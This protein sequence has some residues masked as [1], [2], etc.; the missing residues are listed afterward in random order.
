MTSSS[1]MECV[2]VDIMVFMWFQ[3]ILFTHLIVRLMIA[4][5]ILIPGSEIGLKITA[6]WCMAKTNY[7]HINQNAV[8][9][10]RNG[11]FAVILVKTIT[12]LYVFLL[13]NYVFSPTA[14]EIQWN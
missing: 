4:F 11:N 13:N 3:V 8:F 14:L 7:I 6:K 9:A 12:N 2:D 1:C 5:F 10:D